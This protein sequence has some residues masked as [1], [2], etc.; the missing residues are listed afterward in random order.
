MDEDIL[1]ERQEV[2]KEIANQINLEDPRINRGK[3]HSLAEI[4][5][6][7]LC[8]QISNFN[9][10]REYELYGQRKL[11]FLRKFLPYVNGTPSRSTIGR[12]LMMFSPKKSESLLAD[13]AKKIT[14]P[15][16]NE[17]HVLAGDGKTQRGFKGEGN[18]HYMNLY[19]TNSGVCLGQE[20][21]ND[22]SNEITAFPILLDALEIKGHII[23][24]DAMNCQKQ[25]TKTATD[26]GA[27]YFLALKQNHGTLFDEI[28]TYFEDLNLQSKCAYFKSTDKGHGRIEIRECYTTNDIDWITGKSA[29]TNFNT[30]TMI[31]STRIIKEKETSETRFFISSLTPNAQKHLAVSRAHWGIENSLNWVLD[32]IFQEDSRIIWNKNVAQNESIIRRMALNLVK[33]YQAIHPFNKKS[34]KVALKTIRKMSFIDDEEM[35]AILAGI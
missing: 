26:K 25:T 1:I 16:A 7:V 6:V 32:V 9:T 5:F 2:L 33:K 35:L 20:K 19:D 12:F 27:D 15:A 17:Q 31:K 3:K 18:M 14:K 29:W 10:F 30:I 8:A 28:R 21:V 22:K 11:N 34:E 23:S 4:F 13:W 24:T